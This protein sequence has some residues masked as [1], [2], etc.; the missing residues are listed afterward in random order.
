LPALTHFGRSDSHRKALLNSSL[1][2]TLGLA[3]GMFCQFK[4]N[5]DYR[6]NVCFNAEQVHFVQHHRTSKPAGGQVLIVPGVRQFTRK[7]G[8]YEQNSKVVLLN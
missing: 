6:K 1:D 8:L 4:T 2:F 5:I 7:V 3:Q